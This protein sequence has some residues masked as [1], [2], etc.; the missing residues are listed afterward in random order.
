[1]EDDF[2]DFVYDFNREV[3]SRADSNDYE[4]EEAFTECMCDALVEFGE[5]EDYLPC[6][7]IEKSIGARV[8]AYHFDDDH[9]TVSLVI[10]AW[11]GWDGEEKS[12]GRLTNSEIDAFVKRITKFLSNSLQ[13][14]LPGS[15]ID[16]GHPASDLAQTIRDLKDDLK[17]ARVVVISDGEAP[18]R[19]GTVS[20]VE[21]VEVS[22]SI[23]DIEG[24]TRGRFLERGGDNDRFQRLWKTDQLRRVPEP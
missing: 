17:M 1:M 10:S 8:D 16:D 7:W 21:G 9:E 2:V 18:P 13:G 19:E 24:Y 22:V 4:I 14:K 11:K 3:R 20:Q 12:E 6:S 5:R 23:W 15:R